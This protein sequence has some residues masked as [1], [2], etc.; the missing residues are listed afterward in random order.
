MAVNVL[1]GF[2]SISSWNNINDKNDKLFLFDPENHAVG[3]NPK[4]K[5]STILSMEAFNIWHGGSFPVVV[6]NKLSKRF[7]DLP[8]YVSVKPLESFKSSSS[9]EKF[10]TVQP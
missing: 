6:I 7:S 3:T 9:P 5:E 2:V 1:S 4:S 10:I 8:L